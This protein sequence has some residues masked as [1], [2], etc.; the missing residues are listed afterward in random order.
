MQVMLHI[1]A[2]IIHKIRK[3]CTRNF[4]ILC[5]IYDSLNDAINSSDYAVSNTEY[6]IGKKVEESGRRLYGGICLKG[7]KKPR[8]L[9]CIDGLR[10]EIWTWDL[11]DMKQEGYHATVTVPLLTMLK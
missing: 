3:R 1:I 7:L 11:P 4:N 9:S 5:F 10:A 6:W 8:N 2:A